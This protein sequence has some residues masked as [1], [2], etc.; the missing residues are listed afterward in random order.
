MRVDQR[1]K[2]GEAKALNPQGFEVSIRLTGW[3][4]PRWLAPTNC[5]KKHLWP[6]SCGFSVVS[7]VVHVLG[8]RGVAS[9]EKLRELGARGTDGQLWNLAPS[10]EN[11]F[12]SLI[13]T[14]SQTRHRKSVFHFT[15]RSPLMQEGPGR[16][17]SHMS[18]PVWAEQPPEWTCS[19]PLYANLEGLV[20]RAAGSESHIR[21][22]LGLETIIWSSAKSRKGQRR[23]YTVMV[24]KARVV[25]QWRRVRL[26]SIHTR[27]EK[28]LRSV[29][30]HA[31]TA[32][33]GEKMWHQTLWQSR[34]W[35]AV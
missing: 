33:A 6:E 29:P 9:F 10:Y 16:Y 34:T 19:R 17:R 25:C 15:S 13:H 11:L 20:P 32:D 14:P 5:W 31:G 3:S 35:P 8:L 30:T 23:G 7:L 21:V 1:C 18:V 24:S 27:S 2:A 26:R 22:A 12:W 4:N 28:C